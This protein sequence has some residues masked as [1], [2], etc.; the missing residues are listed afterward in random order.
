MASIRQK[1]PYQ[2]HVQ[3]RRKGWPHQ[4]AT[5]RTRKDAEAWARK[6]E[7]EM[8]R[9]QFVDQS[10]GRQTTLCDLGA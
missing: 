1:G 8:D 3:V 9:G 2:W 4:T 10:T 7:S 6:I 5:I